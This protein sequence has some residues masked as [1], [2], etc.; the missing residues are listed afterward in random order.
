MLTVKEKLDICKLIDTGTSCMI[1]SECYGIGR[2][3]V[4][5]IKNNQEKLEVF[6]KN[7]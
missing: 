1:I 7:G 6:E 5:D 3:K 4:V 2:S